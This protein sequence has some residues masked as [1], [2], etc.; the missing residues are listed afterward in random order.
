MNSVNIFVL[1]VQS[2]MC[3][4]CDVLENCMERHVDYFYN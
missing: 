4:T 3:V 2:P 1:S